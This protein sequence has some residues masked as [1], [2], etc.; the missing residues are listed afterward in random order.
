MRLFRMIQPWLPARRSMP[1]VLTAALKK[2]KMLLLSMMLPVLTVLL[3]AVPNAEI[4]FKGRFAP[5]GP[6]LLLMTI[7]LLF[8]TMVVPTAVVVLKRMFPPAVPNG[9]VFEPRI[10]QFATMLFCAPPT[11]AAPIKRIVLV[12]TAALVLR[13]ERVNEL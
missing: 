5:A 12:V 13:F 4:A 2:S 6:I 10:V 1:A 11:A 3:P 9:T 8:P 7:L